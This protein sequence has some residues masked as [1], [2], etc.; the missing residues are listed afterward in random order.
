MSTWISEHRPRALLAGVLALVL[1]GCGTT[2]AEPEVVRSVTLYGG[3]VVVAGPPGYCID[4]ARVRRGASGGFV[5]LAS[6]DSLTGADT[7]GAAPA[8]MTVSVLPR[9]GQTAPRSDQ[10]AASVA[11][12]K[13]LD[14]SDRNGLALVRVSEGGD[15]ELPGGDPRYWRGGMSVNGHLIGLAVYGP[16]GSDIAGTGGRRL[17]ESLA[18]RIRTAS[19]DE[20]VAT[21]GE[22]EATGPASPR[23]GGLGGLLDALFPNQG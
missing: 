16:A 5:L 7:A 2:G 4:G 3:D 6:C 12:A 22:E 10:I 8:V 21:G 13:A 17:A 19:P 20:P 18:A 11:P 1:A 14:R 15:A 9:Q 23:S